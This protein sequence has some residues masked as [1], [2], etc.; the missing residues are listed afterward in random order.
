MALDALNTSLLLTFC[1]TSAVVI[2]VP[3]PSAM[4]IVGRALTVGR[5][6]AI[7][8]A[9]GNTGG[10]VV[11]G[12]L[13]SLGVGSIVSGSPMIYNL[14]KYLGAAYL[15]RMGAQTVR[16][17]HE[18]MTEV[19]GAASTRT[20][21]PAREGFVVGM[22]NPKTIV[23]FASTLP[24]FVDPSR[25]HVVVQMLLMMAV[26][27]AMSLVGDM[28]WGLAG[29]ALRTW[30]TQSPHRIATLVA[31]GGVCITGLGLLLAFSH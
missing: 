15:V 27:G 5:P 18:A 9:A 6:A 1:V 28:S 16:G 23:F 30:S 22:S 10:L 17:R 8:T 4:F 3:G 14:V 19:D 26:F 25:G 21:R 13:A 20:Q 24:Q 11:Q 29:S 2:A 12:L 31:G 7:A